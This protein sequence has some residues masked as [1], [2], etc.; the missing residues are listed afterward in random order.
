MCL[1]QGHVLLDRS[2]GHARGNGP[3][4]PPT[5]E[6][7]DAT[8]DT[9]FCVYSTSKAVTALVVHMLDERGGRGTLRLE[10]VELVADRV[11]SRE[12]ALLPPAE[13]FRIALALHSEAAN[14]NAV[15]LFE[16]RLKLV[17]PGD[18]IGRARREDLDVAVTRQ[19]LGDVARVKL[20]AAID[21][22]TVPLNDDRDLHCAP[23][24]DPDSGSDGPPSSSNSRSIFS[25][26]ACRAEA[27]L[28]SGG[29]KA[30]AAEAASGSGVT[31]AGR[32]EAASGTDA[33]TSDRE[34]ASGVGAESLQL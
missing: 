16:A 10:P 15:D 28:S 2:I 21:R 11:P 3:Q 1:D 8:P 18:V 34:A 7:V 31:M 24:S 30:D 23:G 22:L 26:A 17:A 19:P 14:W 4:D 32:D 12:D 5:A 25:S 27:A 33:A 29:A 13:Y 6:K 20:S 9:P